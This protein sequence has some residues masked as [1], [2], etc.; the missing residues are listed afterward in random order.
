MDYFANRFQEGISYERYV[1]AGTEEQQRRW[2]QVYEAAQLT[3]AQKS[4]VAGFVREMKILVFSGV[5]C[6]DC[7]EQ[8]PLIYRIC[9]A[10]PEK[11]EMTVFGCQNIQIRD[12][13]GTR[14]M[15]DKT[16]RK[17]LRHCLTA[18]LDG[19]IWSNGACSPAPALC[20]RSAG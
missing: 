13:S 4:L 5:W 20:C 2:R 18:R 10:C 14:K 15:H 12:E 19:V 17:S 11:I 1:A 7:I 3:N 9:E 16:A 6:G 8:C